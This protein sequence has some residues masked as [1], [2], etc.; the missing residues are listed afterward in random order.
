MIII[1]H[2]FAVVKIQHRIV[3]FMLTISLQT[4]IIAQVTL[5]YCPLEEKADLH[6]NLLSCL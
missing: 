5:L 3:L 4:V 6:E 2:S 1:V